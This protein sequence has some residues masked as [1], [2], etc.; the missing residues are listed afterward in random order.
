MIYLRRNQYNVFT[1]FTDER[2]KENKTYFDK[3]SK[4]SI[5]VQEASYFTNLTPMA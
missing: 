4:S 1:Y 2:N 5:E 3:I